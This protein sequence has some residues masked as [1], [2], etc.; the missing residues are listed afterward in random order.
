MTKR[1]TIAWYPEGKYKVTGKTKV[2][3]DLMT[4]KGLDI[5]E[6]DF[7]QT[8]AYQNFADV[9]FFDK[10]GEWVIPTHKIEEKLK[11]IGLKKRMEIK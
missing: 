1:K 6:I 5:K 4:Y 3:A 8:T 11:S 9:K 7:A 2:M 10:K